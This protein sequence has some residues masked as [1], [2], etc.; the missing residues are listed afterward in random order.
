MHLPP[1]A[2]DKS[3]SARSCNAPVQATCNSPDKIEENV[4]ALSLPAT[5]LSADQMSQVKA[6]IAEFPDV[7]AL[8]D[9]E[10]G[11]TNLIKHCVDTGDHLPIKQQPYRTPIVRRAL[12]SEMI[13]EMCEQGIVQP[14][15]SPWASPIVLVPKKD[16]AYHV[17]VDFRCLNAVTKKDGYL[18]PAHRGHS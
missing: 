2:N 12:I 4:D 10:L 5:N 1:I 6:L 17:C 13:N 7:F 8:S 16:G 11:C 3:V 18:F 9:A 15:V 14:S